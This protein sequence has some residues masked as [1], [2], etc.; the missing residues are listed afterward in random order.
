MAGRVSIVQQ[1]A[2]LRA[3][4][5][6][7]DIARAHLVGHSSGGNIA[8]QLA[9]DAPTLVHDSPGVPLRDLP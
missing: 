9:L 1:A 7:L 3:L 4:L 2:H 5:R 6:H 8:L